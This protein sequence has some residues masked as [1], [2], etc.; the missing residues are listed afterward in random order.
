[1]AKNEDQKIVSKKHIVRRQKEHQQQKTLILGTII[2]TVLALLVIVY[3]IMDQY[4]LTQY[5]T[6]AVV[7][8]QRITVK[9]FTEMAEYDRFQAKQTYN[10]NYYIFQMLGEDTTVASS[11]ASN[12]IQIINKLSPSNAVSYGQTLVDQMVNNVLIEQQAKKMGITV[13]EDELNKKMEE[14]FQYSEGVPTVTPTA[15]TFPT[16]LP[17]GTFSS[18]QLA[19]V[20][21]TPTATEAPTETPL[22]ATPT[23]EA[24]ATATP[25]EVTAGESTPTAE[26]TPSMTPT[27]YTYEG[28]QQELKNSMDTLAEYG[29]SES[30]F[31][32]LVKVSILQEKVMKEV[33]KDVTPV[34]TEVWARH[35]LVSDKTVADVL[36]QQLTQDGAD[37]AQIAKEASIDTSNSANGGDLGWFPRHTMVP[38]FDK[39]VFDELKVGEISEPVKTDFGYH[40]IQKLG[41]EQR[42]LSESEYQNY[43]STVYT[44]WLN[45]IRDNSDVTI[46]DIWQTNIPTDITIGADEIPASLSPYVN[47]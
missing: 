46:K 37:F 15:T 29:I 44:A 24:T 12:M 8:G 40:I 10:Y 20:T 31:R 6:V 41:E 23:L 4:V 33:T 13:S 9:D 5:K 35:I 14:I 17:T 18:E 36:Y 34:Q 45:D 39:V 16:M 42:S 26:I 27:E 47:Q 1:M 7:N 25:T 22:P 2:V 3:G 38:A 43:L 21:L 30:F 28:Y 32:D 11:F 19:L